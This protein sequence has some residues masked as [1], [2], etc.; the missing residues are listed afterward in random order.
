[1]NSR[2]VSQNGDDKNYNL[3]SVKMYLHFMNRC[4][5]I[6]NQILNQL[7]VI[8][9]DKNLSISDN[10]SLCAFQTIAWGLVLHYGYYV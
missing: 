5:R 10:T 1:M 8:V 7:E 9:T 3:S 2:A 4:G 6:R